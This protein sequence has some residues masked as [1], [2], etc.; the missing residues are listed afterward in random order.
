MRNELR[1]EQPLLA[2]KGQTIQTLSPVKP[3]SL[4]ESKHRM[5][6]RFAKFTGWGPPQPKTESDPPI[7]VSLGVPITRAPIAP[8]VPVTNN[9]LIAAA[10]KLRD[11]DVRFREL[12]VDVDG[13]VVHLRG[14]VR[15]WE[16]AFD[17]AGAVSRLPGVERV[18]MGEVVTNRRQSLQVP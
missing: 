6:E 14:S 9:D 4:T 1:V 13:N 3:E 12:R 18:V 16:D 10:Q 2:G 15:R 17:L 5:P 7:A 11:A 8:I